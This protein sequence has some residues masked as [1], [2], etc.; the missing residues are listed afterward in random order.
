MG[1]RSF[2]SLMVVIIYSNNVFVRT[3]WRSTLFGNAT[4]G[5]VG[6][7][8]SPAVN[9]CTDVWLVAIHEPTSVTC[10]IVITKLYKLIVD[11][12]IDITDY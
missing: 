11:S 8:S 9:N 1:Y 10:D 4:S 2:A 12:V 3:V 7:M 5:R 6:D